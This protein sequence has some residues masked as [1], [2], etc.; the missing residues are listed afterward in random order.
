VVRPSLIITLP[1]A[2]SIVVAESI[3]FSLKFFACTICIILIVSCGEGIVTGCWAY[4]VLLKT[5]NSR[6]KEKVVVNFKCNA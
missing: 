1:A 6:S 5:N 4:D 2:V 3:V